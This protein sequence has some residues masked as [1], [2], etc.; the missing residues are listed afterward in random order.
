MFEWLKNLITDL[1]GL[2][3]S[4]FG[5]EAATE[6]NE[7]ITHFVSLVLL[8]NYVGAASYLIESIKGSKNLDVDDIVLQAEKVGV[9]L[10]DM[11][12]VID[13]I[14][15]SFKHTAQVSHYDPEHKAI[16]LLESVLTYSSN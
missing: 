7:D 8:K 12:K 2:Y 3:S 13:V 1:F 9:D 6:V 5:S 15:S 4:I 16:N 10:K 14:R 11:T